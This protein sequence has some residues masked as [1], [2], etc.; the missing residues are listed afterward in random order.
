MCFHDDRHVRGTFIDFQIK[1]NYYIKSTMRWNLKFVGCPTHVIHKMKCPT[2]K[3]NI[4]VIQ[5]VPVM[6]CGC[7]SG[8]WNSDS[9]GESNNSSAERYKPIRQAVNRYVS[10]ESI[11][12]HVYG[13]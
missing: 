4:T 10:P 5:H 8:D 3:N 12:I 9:S 11:T 2:N 1:H 6:Y 7:S 13:K